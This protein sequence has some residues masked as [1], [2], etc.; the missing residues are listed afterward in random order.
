MRIVTV[1]CL[2]DNF[3]YL[4]IDEATKRA[5]VVDPGEAAPVIAALAREGVTLGAVWATHHHGDHVGGT[6]ELLRTCGE[7]VPVL[8]HAHDRQTNRIA[9]QTHAVEDGEQVAMDGL[10]AQIIYNPG[11]TLG[12]ISYWLRDAHGG[13]GAVFTGD[14]LFAAGC[15]RVFE[16]TPPMMHASLHRIA[17]LP[18][19]TRVYFGHEYTVSN[20]RFAAAV[21]PNEEA[22]AER[23]AEVTAARAKGEPSTPSVL[24]DELATNPFLRT[25]E[26]S[27]RAAAAARDGGAANDP[28]A[29]FG[30]LRQWKNEFK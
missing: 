15:G 20:L 17:A 2:E 10:R 19:T 14:T 29:A 13:D 1:P 30:V 11:H 3:C 8:G 25:A 7:G 4:V 6:K 27:V 26:A 5:A 18:P 21:E 16:G 28:V 23:A 22:I 24:E 9:G 12:A